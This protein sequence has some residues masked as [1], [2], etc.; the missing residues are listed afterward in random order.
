[1]LKDDEMFEVEFS[2]RVRH[3]E[4]ALL[5]ELERS[6]S[7]EFLAFLFTISNSVTPKCCQ[8]V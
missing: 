3:L 2:V 8:C 1:M 4:R 7:G 5:A 6:T